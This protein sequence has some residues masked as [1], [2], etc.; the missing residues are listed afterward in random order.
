MRKSAFSAP[1]RRLLC[2][3]LFLAL[4]APAAFAVQP[5]PRPMMGAPAKAAQDGG[6]DRLIVRYRAATLRADR[7]AAASAAQGAVQAALGR[8]GIATPHSAGVRHL[9]RTASGGEVVRL[10]RRLDRAETAAL[11]RALKSDPAIA[12]VAPDR[13]MQHTGLPAPRGA[14]AAAPR[15]APDDPYYANYQWHLHHP[16]GGIGAPSAWNAATGEGVVV[17]VLDTGIVE[18]DDL[19]ANV[20][21]GYDFITDPFVSR[22]DTAERVPGAHDYGDWNDDPAQCGVRPSSFH[23]THVAGTVAELTGNGLGMAGVAHGAKVLPV[24]VLGRCGG[25]ESDIAD[26]IVWASGGTVEGVP[27]NPDPA[28]V[29]NLSLGGAGVCT[30]D[31]EFQRAIDQAVANGAT[32]VVAAGND[33]ADAS[34]FSPAGCAHVVAVG[35][36]RYNGGKAGYSSYGRVVDLSAPGGGGAMDGAPNGYVWQA[37]NDSQ[38]APEL[39]EQTYGGMSGTSMAAPHVAGVAA[40]VQSI[41]ETPLTPAQ[42]EALLKDTARPFPASIPSST[43]LGTGILDAYAALAAVAPPC[44]GEGCEPPIEA[45]PIANRSPVTALA[46][47]AGSEQLFSLDVPA[48]VG[49]LTIL[50]YGGS[51]DVTLLVSHAAE[52][53]SA[54][55]D[56]RSARPGN[57]ETVRIA[58]PRAGTYYIKLVGA[59]RFERV[60]LEARH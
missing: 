18:H 54:V 10:P 17:A 8:I 37:I 30:A 6:A 43:P 32:V 59:T 21:E 11:V 19:N 27:A 53:T 60:T 58:A 48:G 40:L 35:A 29:I 44:E 22:R 26:A 46:G 36:T 38:T 4:A 55:A 15:L 5:A 12:Y 13:R 16:T 34:Q 33:N 7:R 41:A 39:G 56:Y 51:G 50:T 23:G 47:A 57:N 52:P 2:G 25:Y 42:M 49:S 45:T 28:E 24:R 20:L 1:R 9:R 31:S 14:G 3:A